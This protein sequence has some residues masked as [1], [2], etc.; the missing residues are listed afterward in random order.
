MAKMRY[1]L[2]FEYEADP[3]EYEGSGIEQWADEDLYNFKDAGIALL[4]RYFERLDI[5]EQK[6]EVIDD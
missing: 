5:A 1:T 4:H 6:V 2:V 3:T